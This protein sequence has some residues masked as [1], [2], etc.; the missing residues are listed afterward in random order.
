[1]MRFRKKIPQHSLLTCKNLEKSVV[2][3]QFGKKTKF[4]KLFPAYHKLAHKKDKQ[5]DLF[6][7]LM[8]IKNAV[9][10]TMS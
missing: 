3:K 8:A 1:M 5:S 7:V 6:D 2:K 4:L 10:V 9:D